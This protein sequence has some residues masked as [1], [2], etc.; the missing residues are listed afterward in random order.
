MKHPPLTDEQINAVFARFDQTEDK[1]KR[2]VIARF[3]AERTELYDSLAEL[4]T[5]LKADL[6]MDAVSPRIGQAV[7]NSAELL[8]ELLAGE[9]P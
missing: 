4:T 2:R 3:I 6:D 7:N 1:L 5:A 8:G 9:L